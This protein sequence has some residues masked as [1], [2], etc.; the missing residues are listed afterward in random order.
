MEDSALLLAFIMGRS[1][2]HMLIWL[3]ARQFFIV[4]QR[5]VR[6]RGA[7]LGPAYQLR[8]PGARL[9]LLQSWP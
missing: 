2:S 9:R 6:S 5:S 4:S 7:R 3:A 1:S 8:M